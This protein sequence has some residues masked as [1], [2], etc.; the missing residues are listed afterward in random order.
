MTPLLRTRSRLCV[1]L[2]PPKSSSPR[3][4][5]KQIVQILSPGLLPSSP[6]S[7]TG[8]G[9]MS[10]IWCGDSHVTVM[11]G[12]VLKTARKASS[13]THGVTIA[14]ASWAVAIEDVCWLSRRAGDTP[15]GNRWY[16]YRSPTKRAAL[17]VQA[18]MIFSW[19]RRQ[20]A[21]IGFQKRV[22]PVG[23]TRAWHWLLLCLRT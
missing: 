11:A 8:A 16:Q 6:P 22:G 15:G 5:P 13:A 19:S 3:G 12:P 20:Y 17:P 21:S 1:R 2:K 7:S 23:T 4:L 10:P 9:S 18:R 14:M